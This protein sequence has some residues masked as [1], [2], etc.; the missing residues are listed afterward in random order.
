MFD[1]N[2]L[3][4]VAMLS[5]M[6]FVIVTMMLW[7]FVPQEGSMKYWAASSLLIT[8]GLLLLGLRSHIP[9]FVSIVIANTV[10]ALGVGFMYVAA[11]MLLGVR[12]WMRVPWYGSGLALLICMVAS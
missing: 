6:G 3:R 10:V 7:R 1:L 2:T 11:C 4:L 12:S 5:F 8:I 9:D